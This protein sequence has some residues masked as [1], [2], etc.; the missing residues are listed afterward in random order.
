MMV[1]DSTA[2]GMREKRLPRRVFRRLRRWRK[3]LREPHLSHI[4][5]FNAKKGLRLKA[6][7]PFVKGPLEPKAGVILVMAQD[8]H[9]RASGAPYPG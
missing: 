9:E 5:G 6:E 2:G 3:R 1:Q 7:V 4:G 8:D